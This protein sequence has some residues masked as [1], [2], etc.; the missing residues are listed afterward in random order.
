MIRWKTIMSKVVDIREKKEFL[1]FT[2]YYTFLQYGTRNLA[3]WTNR[4]FYN[5]E[6][7][8]TLQLWRAVAQWLNIDGK[9]QIYHHKVDI[10]NYKN[11]VYI[12]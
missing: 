11:D 10:L 1:I 8:E 6:N 3:K 5:V 9:N 4:V 12:V 2:V 7:H